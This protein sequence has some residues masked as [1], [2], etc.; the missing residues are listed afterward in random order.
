MIA[1]L[2]PNNIGNVLVLPDGRLGLLDYGMVGRFSIEQ[3]DAVARAVLALARGDKRAVAD[4]YLEEGYHI[5][6]KN[7][8]VT[9]SGII[10]RIASTQL[11]KIDFSP[12]TLDRDDTTPPHHPRQIPLKE[13]I[14]NVDAHF[15]P[16]W[17]FQVRRVGRLLMGV[18]AQ[19]ARPISLAKE[20]EPIAKRAILQR[21][22][23]SEK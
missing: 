19:A 23:P 11:D 12:V 9:D 16:S 15:V 10:H 17:M 22:H 1:V 18:S 8:K 20:W 3:R 14:H 21:R 13:L 6:Y 4:L 7:E 5:T 2:N